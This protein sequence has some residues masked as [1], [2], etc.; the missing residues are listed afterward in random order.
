MRHCFVNIKKQREIDRLILNGRN[1]EGGPASYQKYVARE[2]A[3]NVHLESTR[4]AGEI[5]VKFYCE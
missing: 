4:A 1:V 3:E 5:E 2:K